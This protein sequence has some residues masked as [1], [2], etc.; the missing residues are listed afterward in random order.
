MGKFVSWLL[1]LFVLWMIVRAV[2]RALG[3]GRP[4][5]GAPR[6]RESAQPTERAGGRLVRDPQCGTYVP[7]GRAIRIGTGDETRCF[8]STA[9]RDAYL[10]R[11]AR[12]A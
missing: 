3:F 4:P 12:R 2:S 7:E 10:G 11:Q 9:C 5:T 8:C 6:Q 1:D